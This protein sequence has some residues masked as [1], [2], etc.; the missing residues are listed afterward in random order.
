MIYKAPVKD[1]RLMVRCDPETM[2]WLEE[3]AAALDSS[4]GEIF[5][6]SLEAM[7]PQLELMARAA[8]AARSGDGATA[9]QI[10]QEM[11]A[12]G[13]EASEDFK[14]RMDEEESN[15]AREVAK[16]SSAAAK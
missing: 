8:R 5:R 10:V 3:V 16:H 12:Q 9:L 2:A 6:V 1:Q 7:R 4:K 15:L 11:R 13:L 14:R